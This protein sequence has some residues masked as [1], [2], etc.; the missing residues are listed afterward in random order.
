MPE[1]PNTTPPAA[2]P[3]EAATVCAA[4]WPAVRLTATLLIVRTPPWAIVASALAAVTT[5]AEA[6]AYLAK[7]GVAYAGG[8]AGLQ[9]I[10]WEVED[11]QAELDDLRSRGVAIEEYDLPE[12]KT[13]NGIADFGFALMAWIIDPGKNALSILVLV[14]LVGLVPAGEPLGGKLMSPVTIDHAQLE[15][16]LREW[17]PRQR[18]FAAGPGRSA[19]VASFAQWHGSQPLTAPAP[20]AQLWTSG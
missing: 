10:G 17:L 16:L 2:C 6:A 3:P 14:F 13:E 9:Q 5:A 1:R 7:P 18:W 11:L 20:T 12:L 4:E 8:T 19:P 15:E